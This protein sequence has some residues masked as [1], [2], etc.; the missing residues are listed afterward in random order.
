MLIPALAPWRGPAPRVVLCLA[1][2]AVLCVS[3]SLAEHPAFTP[4]PGVTAEDVE[5]SAVELVPHA[6]PVAGLVH[7]GYFGSCR[8][9]A[10]LVPSGF[11]VMRV[12]SAA[13]A[14]EAAALALGY[15]S[16]PPGCAEPI[17]AFTAVP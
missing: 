8:F 5:L 11:H 7:Q 6:G 3:P 9:L 2:A 4:P 12:R 15:G 10:P 14:A 17:H 13:L 1:C 16:P